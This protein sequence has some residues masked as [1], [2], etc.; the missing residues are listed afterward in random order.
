MTMHKTVT[1]ICF[2][3]GGIFIHD[4]NFC[5]RRV[6]NKRPQRIGEGR[7]GQR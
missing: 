5:G 6:K 4:L 2:V 7:F 1:H 3:G